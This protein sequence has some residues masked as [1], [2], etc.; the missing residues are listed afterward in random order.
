MPQNICRHIRPSG[1]R[2][3][4]PAVRNRALCYFHQNLTEK[5]NGDI[6]TFL[7]TVASIPPKHLDPDHLRRNPLEQEYFGIRPSGPSDID[8]PPLEDRDSIQI[9]L[10]TILNAL[11]QNRIDHR[12]AGTLLYGLQIAVANLRSAYPTDAADAASEPSLEV[13]I[14][15]VPDEHGQLLCPPASCGVR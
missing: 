1:R 12:R 11:A 2:C 5:H 14:D 6:P 10:S 9:A 13:V 7:Q 4:T 3:Q 8:L 15:T